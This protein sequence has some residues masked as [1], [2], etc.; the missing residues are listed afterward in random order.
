VEIF[1]IVKTVLD[2]GVAGLLLIGLIVLWRQNLKERKDH[3]EDLR[4][5]GTRLDALSDARHKEILDLV[6]KYTELLGKV[7]HQ[8]ELQTSAVTSA[9]ATIQAAASRSQPSL[10]RGG[11]G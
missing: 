2:L 7:E 11:P 9:V 10:R 3:A 8:L 6:T 1:E 5:L 4:T